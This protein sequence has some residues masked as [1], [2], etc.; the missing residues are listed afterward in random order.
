MESEAELAMVEAIL[1]GKSGL[2]ILP[3]LM[4]QGEYSIRS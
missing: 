2:K 1:G 3:P 4:D